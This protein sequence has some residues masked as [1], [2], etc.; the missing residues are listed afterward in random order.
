MFSIVYHVVHTSIRI[1]TSHDM[2]FEAWY[3]FDASTS[4]VY[5]LILISQ[6]IASIQY[7]SIF[8]GFPLLYAVM[9]CVA[10]SQLE[11]LKAKIYDINQKRFT[12]EDDSVREGD[13]QKR[14][15]ECVQHHQLIMRYMRVLEDTMN[16]TLCGLLL[17]LSITLCFLAFS[18]AMSLEDRTDLA[19]ALYVYGLV[20]GCAFAFCSLGTELSEQAES[21][22]D[23]VWSCDWVGTPV[24]FQR[25]LVFIMATANKEFTLT[26]GKFVPVCNKT[27]MN[28]MNQSASFFM[29]LLTMIDKTSRSNDTD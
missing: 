7:M 19:Q 16:F 3:P 24:P 20:L 22:T 29:F 6:V 2:V 5:E 13:I 28:M 9:V 27:M 25:C 10:C 18:A 12:S 14:L 26:A 17:M 23:E 4:P 21:V 8:F 11:K 15:H 1:F